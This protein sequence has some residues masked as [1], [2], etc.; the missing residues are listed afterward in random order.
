MAAADLTVRAGKISC[1]S[2]SRAV[3][4]AFLLIP[5]VDAK[6]VVL[7]PLLLFRLEHVFVLFCEGSRP[8][9]SLGPGKSESNPGP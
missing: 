5:E 9:A 1:S 3:R 6:I 8:V 2:L 4:L 7:W